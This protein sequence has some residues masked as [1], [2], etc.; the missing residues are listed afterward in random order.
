MWF[1][2]VIG[3]PE[4][5]A[6]VEQRVAPLVIRPDSGDPVKI[7][8]EVLEKLEKI[9]PVKLN[10][11]GFKVLPENV[12]VLQVLNT[13]DFI[14]SCWKFLTYNFSKGDGVSRETLSEMLETLEQNMWSLDN[15]GFGSG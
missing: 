4:L 5:K 15:V 2:K 1:V 13:L 14:S 6:K 8:I 10:S 3:D 12:R 9:F 11:K 7:I